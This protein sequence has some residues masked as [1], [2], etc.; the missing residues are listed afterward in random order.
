MAPVTPS[1]C[2]SSGVVPS[3]R[4]WQSMSSNRKRKRSLQATSPFTFVVLCTYFYPK[5]SHAS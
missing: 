4:S 2:G 3:Y 5:L 1:S